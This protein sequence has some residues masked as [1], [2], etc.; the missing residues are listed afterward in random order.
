MLSKEDLDIIRREIE[1]GDEYQKIVGDR[2]Y[3][4]D[5]MTGKWEEIVEIETYA[6][7]KEEFFKN[8]PFYVEGG[9]LSKYFSDLE[10]DN[11]EGD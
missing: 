10:D 6:V 3:T 9:P 11:E 8:S 2:A 5:A 7:S 4:F 1:D